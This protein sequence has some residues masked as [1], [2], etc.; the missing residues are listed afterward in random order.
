MKINKHFTIDDELVRLLTKESNASEL[1]NSLLLEYYNKGAVGKEQLMARHTQLETKLG[2][3]EAQ[4]AQLATQ[5][6][7]IEIKEEKVKTVLSKLP[8]EITDDFYRFPQMTDQIL[9]SRFTNLY[10]PK[11]PE[12]K[13][14]ELLEAFNNFKNDN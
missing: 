6:A 1:I 12:L 5:L 4:K 9:R 14:I 2:E 8:K 11:F 10:R 13:W 3:I 7:T